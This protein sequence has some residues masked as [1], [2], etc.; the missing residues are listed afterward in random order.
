METTRRDNAPGSLNTPWRLVAT[1]VFGPVSDGRVLVTAELD[2]TRALAQIQS[3][4]DTGRVVTITHAFTAALARAIAHDVPEVNCAIRRGRIVPRNFVDI[5]LAAH[6]PGS[7]DMASLRLRDV[8]TR[9]V[10]E[11]AQEIRDLAAEA[12]RG[13][14]RGLM[15]AKQVFSRVP[16]PLRT[17]FTRLYKSLVHGLGVEIPRLGLTQQIF[18]SVGLSNI[19]NFGLNHAMAALFPLAQLPAV[20]VIGK[21]EDKVVVRD[22][23]VVRRWMLPVSITFDHRLLDGSH[24]GRLT[25]AIGRYLDHPQGLA[26][27]T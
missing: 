16:W 9:S 4:R 8:H 15:R 22:D 1:S 13:D 6:I 19:G 5:M 26:Q 17:A 2:L 7:D 12:R 25:Q 24:V 3:W 27:P 21:L 10:F 23:A 20:I 11:L 14:D 18:G